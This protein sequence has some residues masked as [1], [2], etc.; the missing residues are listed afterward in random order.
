M[1]AVH[2]LAHVT[3][4]TTAF[5]RGMARFDSAAPATFLENFANGASAVLGFPLFVLLQFLPPRAFPGLS[6]YLPFAANSLLWG[7]A[8]AWLFRLYQARPGH[9][10][11]GD[12]C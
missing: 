9:A 6:G 3:A 11:E 2:F 7:I 10:R 12:V 1:A 4:T 5:A 8:I